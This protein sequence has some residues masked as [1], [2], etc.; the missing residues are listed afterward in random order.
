MDGLRIAIQ[1]QL[2]DNLGPPAPSVDSLIATDGRSRSAAASTSTITP[3]NRVET[4]ANDL[5]L[6]FC[7][8]TN[9]DVSLKSQ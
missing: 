6:R 3:E 2:T 5:D 1:H 9:V 8:E 7:P 4:G